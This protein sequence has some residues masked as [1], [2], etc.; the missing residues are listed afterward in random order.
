[1]STL[2]NEAPSYRTMQLLRRPKSQRSCF[3]LSARA[4]PKI[5]GRFTFLNL[6]LNRLV[7]I[8]AHFE[9]P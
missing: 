3:D 2:L 8:A 6:P 1:M 4:F 7:N 5:D 9:F